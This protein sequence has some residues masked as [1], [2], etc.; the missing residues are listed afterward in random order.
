M[1]RLEAKVHFFIS[2]ENF[3]FLHFLEKIELVSKNAVFFPAPGEKK[4]AF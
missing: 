4:K 1:S 2:Q 3:N